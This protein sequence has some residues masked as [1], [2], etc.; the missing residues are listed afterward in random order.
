MEL[1]VSIEIDRVLAVP[2]DETI[3]ECHI[4]SR[5]QVPD[6]D[7]FHHA[8]PHLARNKSQGDMGHD[9]EEPIPTDRQ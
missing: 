4:D 8:L 1:L 6:R 3:L 5:E 2:V 9:P 7:D